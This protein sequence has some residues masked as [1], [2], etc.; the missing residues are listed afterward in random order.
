VLVLGCCDLGS[1]RAEQCH[2][3]DISP[4]PRK[5]R[6]NGA[7]Q[8]K[9]AA[10]EDPELSH[11]SSKVL[12]TI[13]SSAFLIS[14]PLYE[15]IRADY[16]TFTQRRWATQDTGQTKTFSSPSMRSSLR[17][18][19]EIIFRSEVIQHCLQSH[20]QTDLCQVIMAPELVLSTACDS[21]ISP[22]DFAMGFRYDYADK[23]TSLAKVSPRAMPSAVTISPVASPRSTSDRTTSLHAAALSEL[24]HV[25]ALSELNHAAPLAEAE[26]GSACQPPPP[27]RAPL[28]DTHAPGHTARLHSPPH[29]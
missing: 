26:L 25:A 7:L 10:E 17:S 24:Q 27:P 13:S 19:G 15:T 4:E 6:K 20:I 16:A 2:R 22:H 12:H 11:N 18:E 5:R 21:V 28:Y 1:G 23:T 9:L 29:T 8:Q 3:M 14:G